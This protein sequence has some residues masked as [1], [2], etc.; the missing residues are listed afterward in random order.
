MIPDEELYHYAS[1][2]YDPV[3]AHEYY[4]AH[5]KLKGR[6]SSA[7]L[8]DEGKEKWDYVRNQISEQKKS[9]IKEAQEEKSAVIKAHRAAAKS[10]Q[11]RI[12][13][14]LK[15]LKKVLAQRAKRELE[16]IR[17]ET[18]SPNARS[19]SEE[20]EN[21]AKRNSAVSKSQS[22]IHNESESA[23]TSAAIE[24]KRIGENLKSVCEATREAYKSWKSQTDSK[25]ET[26]YQQE[27]DKIYGE[28]AKP[29]KRRRRSSS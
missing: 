12:S 10:A 11:K 18:A 4:E 27:Y 8:T 19:K 5:K 29:V 17:S 13:T 14:R 1:P 20:R 16:Q 7:K 26:V 2:Y 28:N 22:S 23:S 3:K 21:L 6:R 9:E 15:R 25:Y 24:R